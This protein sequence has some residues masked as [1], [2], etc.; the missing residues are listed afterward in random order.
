MTHDTLPPTTFFASRRIAEMTRFFI[1][2][3]HQENAAA[4]LAYWTDHQ[5]CSL[6]SER[7]GSY[8]VCGPKDLSEVLADVRQY[9]T[10]TSPADLAAWLAEE[11]SFVE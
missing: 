5:E 8:V 3:S 7:V 11:T 2:G 4:A 9:T 1:S 10:R 6:L